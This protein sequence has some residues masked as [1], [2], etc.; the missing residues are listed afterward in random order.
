MVSTASIVCMAISLIIAFGLPIGLYAGL[1]K[2]FDLHPVPMLVGAAVFIVFALVLESLLHVVVLR[3]QA[4]GTIALRDN[5]PALYVLYGIFAAGVFEETGRF[6]GFALLK[7][8]FHGVRTAVSYGIGH[9]GIEAIMLL[10]MS[11]ISNIVLSLMI[12]FGSHSSTAAP[13]S[14]VTALTDT[15]PW[16]FLVGGGERVLAVAIQISL[17]IVVWVAVTRPGHLWMYPLAIVLHAISDLPAAIAQTGH[18]SI[19]WTEGLTA[20]AA[21]C[22]ATYGLWWLRKSLAEERLAVVEPEPLVQLPPPDPAAL[23]PDVTP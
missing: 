19:A 5:N 17:S 7:R 23:I 10:G 11:M 13:S 2:R 20:V 14:T 22:L 3:P 18:L 8:K 6:V 1:R 4:D 9:G 15:A 21:I 12:N 16:M